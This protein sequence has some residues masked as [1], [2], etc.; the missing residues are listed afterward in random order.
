MIKSN[1]AAAVLLTLSAASAHAAI[2]LQPVG[3]Y[4]SPTA[5]F[6]TGAAEI[7]AFDASTR[8]IFVVNAQDGTVD[9]LDGSNP[10]NPVKIT[11]ID[12]KTLP[13]IDPATL[14]A[15]NSVAARNGLVAVAIEANPVTANGVIAFYDAAT[16]DLLKTVE[17][18]ALPDA[19]TFSNT[20]HF[21]IVS[22]EGEP[23]T[24]VDPQ[25]SVTIVDLRRRGNRPAFSSCTAGFEAFNAQRA[26]LVAS[27]VYIDPGAATVA[28]DL[29]PEYA[30]AQGNNAY[31]TLQENNAIAVVQLNQCRVSR[32][33]PIGVKDHGL[34]ENAL[35]T[36]DREISSGNGGTAI[37]SWK[38]LYALYQP[39][40]IASY[41]AAD[42]ETYLV[43]ANE[44]DARDT[45]NSGRPSTDAVRVGS[46]KL[47]SSAFPPVPPSVS[48][49]PNPASTKNLGR[50]NVI[51][52]LGCEVPLDAAGFC[53]DAAGNAAEYDRLYAYGGRS[54]SILTND[55]R[56]VYDSANDFESI[57]A[58]KVGAGELPR[59]AFNASHSN[60]SPGLIPGQ[61]TNTFDSRSD[62]KGPEPEGVAVGRV[63]ERTY[64]FVGLERIGG[65]MIY[66]VTDPADAFY[67]D[68]VNG[69]AV[70]DFEQP[71][72][73]Q[74]VSDASTNSGN[75]SNGVPNP[76]AGD[77]GPEGLAFVPAGDSPSGKPLLI[78][79][80]EISGS[81]R[82]Y[83]VVAKD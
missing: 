14:G 32:I 69:K 19:V 8:R 7:V 77:L 39:D 54:F 57:I 44:G 35:D 41:E 56:M 81:T 10:A 80:N 62:D 12:V 25:G 27:G 11:Q 30:T 28:Q 64:A 59:Q 43:I 76:A 4:Q 53:R 82:V 29:E 21:V 22:N 55:G 67:V 9:V 72:C 68:Y 40:S 51:R 49:D 50:L 42:G 58:N 52:S 70:R 83:E 36:S 78:V 48:A 66:D 15:A 46:L 60:N 45:S 3:R 37:R 2:T 47:D 63:G 16:L 26:V 1:L 6:D 20:G 24:P 61:S 17:A 79:G 71:V 33:M 34:A 73:T 5:G 74:V 38:N 75:C 65:V 18:G 13:G 31:V 23:R